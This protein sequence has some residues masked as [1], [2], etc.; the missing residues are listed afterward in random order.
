MLHDTL[1]PYSWPCSV[2]GVWLRATET[3]ISAALRAHAAREEELYFTLHDK[4]IHFKA[5]LT[6]T[7]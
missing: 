3:E 7:V 2:A 1:A 4:E 6:E 5:M